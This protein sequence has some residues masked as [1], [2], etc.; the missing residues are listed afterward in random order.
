MAAHS[1]RRLACVTVGL[2]AVTF[3]STAT[4]AQT[5]HVVSPIAPQSAQLKLLPTPR[6]ITPGR[7]LRLSQGISVECPGC[8]ADD[9]FAAENLREQLRERGLTVSAGAPVRLRLMRSS[10]AGTLLASEH[11]AFSPEMT[12]EGYAIVPTSDGLNLIGA[13][14]TGVFYAAETAVQMVNGSGVNAALTTATIRDWPTLKYRGVQDDLSRG[15]VPTLEFQKKQI[16]TLAAYKVNLY[17]PYFEHT[18]QYRGLPLAAPPGGSV[19]PGEARELVA[20]AAKFH[21]MVVPEQEA[22]GHLHYVLNWDTYAPL[23]ETQHGNVLAPGQPGS[24]ALTKQMFTELAQ[25]Y[26]APFLHLG[27]DETLDLGKGQTAADVNARGLGAVYLDYLQ[28]ITAELQPLG[29]RILFWGDIAMHDPDLVK[30][31]PE[32]FKRQTIAIPWEYN[33]QPRGFRRFIQPFTDAG[34]ECWVAPGV[35]D[36]N[37]VFPNNNLALPNIQ[38]FTAQGEASGCT[39]QLNTVWDDDGE[40]LFNGNWYGILFGAEAAWHKGEANIEGFQNSYG[41]VF[42]GDAT[43]KI[44]QA[45]EELMAAHALLKSGFKASDGTNLLF[46]VDPWSV[47]G[48]RYAGMIRPYTRDLRLHAERAITLVAEARAEGNLRESDAL[49]VIDLG[50]RRMDLIGLKFELTDEMATLYAN[51]YALQSSREKGSHEEV[52]RDLGDINSVNGK[53]EDLRNTYSLLRDL[54]SQAWLR[55]Y[56]PYWLDNVTERY[57]LTIQTWLTRMDKVRAAQRQWG[58]TETLPPAS[59]VGIPPAPTPAAPTPAV[60][61]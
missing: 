54:Y 51:A 48:Q 6:E 50:A 42:H 1:L 9:T 14:A 46:W 53:L 37:R 12:A 19:S 18:M 27:A 35:N 7:V 41:E 31:L 45:E 52:S 30:A 39:G 17:S 60:H 49:D 3:G 38:Q 59:E 24:L 11:I 47:D 57:D 20:Y 15:P 13:S 58:N 29:R 16:R 61:P 56:R 5:Q 21:V 32:S 44:N 26:P 2:A 8:N 40:A 43:G 55:S 23:A 25:D 34:I 28:K 33:P 10:G 22:F 4:P 36:W